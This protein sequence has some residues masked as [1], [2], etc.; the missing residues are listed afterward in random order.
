[1]DE[2]HKDGDQGE[3]ENNCV[4]P[5]LHEVDEALSF[6]NVYRAPAFC[7]FPLLHEVDEAPK[8]SDKFAFDPLRVFPLLHE[9]DEAQEKVSQRHRNRRQVFFHFYMKWMKHLM[10]MKCGT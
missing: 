1:M 7:V 6:R 5:L 2:A 4:F 9:V 10:M 8:L 3:C